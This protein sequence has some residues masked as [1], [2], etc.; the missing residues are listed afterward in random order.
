MVE[1][2]PTCEQQDCDQADC[3]PETPVLKQRQK[4]RSGNANETDGSQN[5]GGNGH[6]ADI[7]ERAHKRWFWSF[8]KVSNNPRVYMLRGQRTDGCL[9]VYSSTHLSE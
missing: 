4:I 7:V 6:C 8:R 3:S 2:V 5:N 9:L 1:H